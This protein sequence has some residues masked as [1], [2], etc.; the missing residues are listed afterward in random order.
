MSARHVY[1]SRERMRKRK[2]SFDYS[3]TD[4]ELHSESEITV[5]LFTAIDVIAFANPWIMPPKG[6]FT[7]SDIHSKEIQRR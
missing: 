6:P 5:D 1:T 7:L 3:A 4:H 2:F